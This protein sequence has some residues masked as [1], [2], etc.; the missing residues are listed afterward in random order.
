MPKKFIAATV[1][2]VFTTH[3]Y[4]SFTNGWTEMTNTYITVNN[5]N[6]NSMED[7]SS[8]ES[9]STWTFQGIPVSYENRKFIIIFTRPSP[10]PD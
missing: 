1:H 7:S 4:L 2:L 8:S 6:R 5:A 9:K 3:N 10:K